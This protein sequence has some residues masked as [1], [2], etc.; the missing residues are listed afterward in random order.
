MRYPVPHERR[1]SRC[2]ARKQNRLITYHL[3]TSL[4]DAFTYEKYSLSL[5]DTANLAQ[6]L[7][8]MLRKTVVV[9][10]RSF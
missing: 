1:I 5:V 9:S 2:R 6:F 7:V 8:Q 4:V 10:D 3:L